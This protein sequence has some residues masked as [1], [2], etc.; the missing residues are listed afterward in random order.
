MNNI[1]NN[2]DNIDTFAYLVDV[3]TSLNL[4]KENFDIAIGKLLMILD[5]KT[6]FRYFSINDNIND[7]IIE[8]CK[9]NNSLEILIKYLMIKNNVDKIKYIHE[10]INLGYS[11]LRIALKY[12][13]DDI[14]KYLISAG[15][16]DC[17]KMKL[18]EL[19]LCNFNRI[20]KMINLKI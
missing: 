7:N 13:F 2:I 11:Y 3:V 15:M 20:N 1:F 17:T 10:K 12:N 5:K 18:G 19:E 9:N 4:N 16:N 6:M 14:S 8:Y